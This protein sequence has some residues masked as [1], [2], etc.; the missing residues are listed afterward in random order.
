MHFSQRY[1]A[2][3]YLLSILI[4]SLKKRIII[5][6]L[7]FWIGFFGIVFLRPVCERIGIIEDEFWARKILWK[8][9]FDIII[10]GDS[11]SLIAV[12]PEVMQ[13]EMQG[14]RIGNFSFIALVYTPEYLA[15]MERTLKKD[16]RNKTIILAISPRSLLDLK[17]ENCYFKEWYSKLKNPLDLILR[18]HTG[19]LKLC[20]REITQADIEKILSSWQPSHLQAFMISGWMPCRLSPERIGKTLEQYRERFKKKKVKESDLSPILDA[21]REWKK[22]G[23]SVYAIRIPIHQKMLKIEES[24]SGF[25]E[26]RFRRLF[27]AAGGTWLDFNNKRYHSYDGSH[28]RYD[29]AV[30]FSR[31]LAKM[32]KRG[33][34]N[35]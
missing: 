1:R 34:R 21:T 26:K 11:R 19:W 5:I 27:K 10:G 35:I 8:N 3:V 7:I 24:I 17:G 9:E 33:I 22:K 15:A 29:S 16:S 14:L 30:M 13:E 28:L 12:S 20:F 4:M 2:S 25:N 18:K 6:G 32:I 31:D 23:I